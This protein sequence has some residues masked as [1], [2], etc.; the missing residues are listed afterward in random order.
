MGIV[1]VVQVGDDERGCVDHG[2]RRVR[3]HL[4]SK[5]SIGKEG[6]TGQ[7]LAQADK[8]LIFVGLQKAARAVPPG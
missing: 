1:R 3:R 7:R 4:R 8:C 2:R 6:A 5:K